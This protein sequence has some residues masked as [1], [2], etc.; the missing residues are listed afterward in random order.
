MKVLDDLTEGKYMRTMVSTADSPDSECRVEL[1]TRCFC[2][3]IT[4]LVM[5]L[6]VSLRSSVVVVWT[7]NCV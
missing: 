3:I 5:K 7:S 1:M 2:V 4:L 6:I